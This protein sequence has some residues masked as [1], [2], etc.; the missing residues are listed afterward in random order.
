MNR[1]NRTNKLFEGNLR[2]KWPVMVLT[3]ILL[4]MTAC[5]AASMTDGANATSGIFEEIIDQVDIDKEIPELSK[6]I[7][8]GFGLGAEGFGTKLDCTGG[9]VRVMTDGTFTFDF[10]DEI[11]YEGELSAENYENIVNGLDIRK[12]YYLKVE[13]NENVC[14]GN[15]RYL[16]FYGPDD[17][18][19]N[20]VGGYE[21]TTRTFTDAWSLLMGNLPIQDMYKVLWD[22]K[23][24]YRARGYE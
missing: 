12:L 7:L 13:S 17:T 15:S 2:R 4:S 16:E 10:M 11:I 24:E 23:D 8:V 5:S 1:I 14:D 6:N 3:L 18:V 21:P 22:V 20:R 9:T 19:I